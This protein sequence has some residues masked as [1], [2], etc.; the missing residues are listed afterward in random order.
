[1]TGDASLDA[2]DGAQRDSPR[3]EAPASP[4]SS[5]RPRPGTPGSAATPPT[6]SAE[7]RRWWR[8]LRRTSSQLTPADPELPQV[9]EAPGPVSLLYRSPFQIGFLITMG[10]LVAFG[11]LAALAAL[12]SVLV[13][14]L[15]SLY[16]ALGL[17]PLVDSL[18]R[19]GLR[20]GFAV[21]LVA[22]GLLVLIALGAWAVLPV[23]TEQ[24]NITVQNTAAYLQTLRENPQVAGL[25]GQFDLLNR[26]TS[27]MTS[28]AW[29]EGLFGGILG[30]SMAIAN[31]VFSLVVTLVLTLWF[32]ASLPSI[33]DTI[34][35]LAPASRRPRAKYLANEVFR[36]ISGYMSGLF[37][38]VVLA[39]GSAFLFLNV[40][41]LGPYSLALSVVVALFA[42]IPIVGPT[43]SM[44]IVSLVAFSNNTTI[45]IVTLVFFIVYQQLDA[46]LLQPRVFQRSVNVPGPLI[47]LAAISGG[48]LFGIAGALLA[49][50]TVA[51]LLLLYR[52]VVIPALDRA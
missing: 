15:L 46:Y 17:S 37:T 52:E 23:L 32:L 35:Q 39:S 18:H 3:E 19:S 1:M 8:K 20:R 49:I 2:D 28:G 42:F 27:V 31:I 50:P 4:A 10:G 11:L 29:I 40:V 38:I 21:A 44:L 6:V 7:P 26:V 13:L 45:G 33:K 43:L 14:G 5:P 36:R 41:G 16:L 34:Y 51:S 9:V 22:V 30:A 47:V 48:V 24:V 25:D 12:Q